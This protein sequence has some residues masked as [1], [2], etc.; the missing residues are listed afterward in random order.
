M[1]V[2]KG[3]LAS[4]WAAGV[5]ARYIGATSKLKVNVGR[6]GDLGFRLTIAQDSI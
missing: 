3:V 1:Y 5:R 2:S 4:E 6:R